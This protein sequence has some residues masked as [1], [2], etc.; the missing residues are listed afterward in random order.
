MK[1]KQMFLR[2]GRSVIL[3]SHLNERSLSIAD[4]VEAVAKELN[5]S[6]ASRAGVDA[7]QSAVVS[8]IMG[9]RTREQAE[10]NFGALDISF[11]AEQL[12]RPDEASALVADI[13]ERFI[14]RPMAQQLIS[15]GSS[16][17]ARVTP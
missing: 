12:D 5:A 11:S 1:M 14:G 10:D 15:G 17:K 4:A 6:I 13:P 7:P 16:V 9:A 2:R 3:L 8:P